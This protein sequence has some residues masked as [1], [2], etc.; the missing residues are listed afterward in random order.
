MSSP[1]PALEHRE[2]APVVAN[3]A[4]HPAVDFSNVRRSFPPLDFHQHWAAHEG[5]VLHDVLNA[6]ARV[7]LSHTS[8]SATWSRFDTMSSRAEWMSSLA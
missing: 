6:R 3:L 1:L 4:D 5:S 2:H 8:L 7:L